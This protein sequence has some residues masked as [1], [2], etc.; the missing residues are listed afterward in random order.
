[1][2]RWVE[3]I[4]RREREPPRRRAD[5][6]PLRPLP[7]EYDEPPLLEPP[8]AVLLVLNLTASLP[9]SLAVVLSGV[10]VVRPLLPFEP[11]LL[12]TT[13]LSAS[14]TRAVLTGGGVIFVVTLLLPAPATLA[15]G[16][17]PPQPVTKYC[18]TTWKSEETVQ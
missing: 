4:Y 8:A 11:L 16:A 6:L 9:F 14:A 1:M 2:L 17:R 3:L 18:C 13:F 12:L 15:A 7:R 5:A 10:V